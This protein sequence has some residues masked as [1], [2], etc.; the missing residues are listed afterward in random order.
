MRL[1]AVF[2]ALIFAHPLFPAASGNTIAID[3]TGN[4]WRT[5]ETN[6]LTTTATA[7]QKTAASSVCGMENLSPFQDPT[8]L[9]CKH[10]YLIK[11]D[12]AGNVLYATYL[13]GRSQDGGTAV[14]SDAEGNIYVTGYTY[15]RDFPISA[16]AAQAGNAGPL[17]PT[18]VTRTVTPFGP[19]Y[20]AA[21]GDVFVAKFDVNGDLLFSTL[22]GGSG[23][24]APTLI[25]VDSTGSVYVSGVTAS[26]DFPLTAGAVN[27]GAA[28]YFFARLNATGTALTYSTYFVASILAFDVDSMG[29]AY[30]TGDT[31]SPP[32]FGLGEP[33]LTTLDIQAGTVSQ[34]TD[35][36]AITTT[37]AG[38]AIAIT[39]SQEVFLA[40]S[41]APLAGSNSASVPPF[42][43]LGEAHL[44]KL[45]ADGG[46]VLAET[47]LSHSRFDAIVLDVAGNAYALGYGT[48][49]IPGTADQLLDS[50]CSPDGGAFVL[51]A[52]QEGTVVAATYFRH[53]DDTAVS[54]TSPGHI[55]LYR[56]R[57][58]TTVPL[59]LTSQPAIAFGCPENLAS[60][61]VAQGIAPGEIFALTGSG[62][63]PTQGIGALPDS[64][65]V[66]PTSL[67]GVQ[68]LFDSKPAP[69]L[70]VQANEIHAVA[71]FALSDQPVIE[72]RSDLS[73]ALLDLSRATYDPGIFNV[74][75]QGAIINQDGTVN[76]PGNPASLGSVV[77]IYATGLGT[78]IDSSRSLL[79][80]LADGE[81]TP[82]P[83]PYIMTELVAPQVT[84]AGIPGT[85]LWSGSAP[86]LVAG[87]TQVNVQLP[88]TLPPGTALGSVP[89]TLG[90]GPNVSPPV[91]MN[92]KQ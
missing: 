2:A 23:S 91:F 65:G 29:R 30:L 39:S 31:S 83:P 22:I 73:A 60:Q 79:N 63:G 26:S 59:D 19:S 43:P 40:V 92:L 67:G 17:T 35:L 76:A 72:V 24:D 12:G 74:N 18:V 37:G 87:V 47:K 34:S 64:S 56:T 41:P 75:G 7:F 52:N 86:G 53:G 21:G 8:P 70:F 50:P 68:V 69:L 45:P 57:S 16:G 85:T 42:R 49:A 62:L 13:G 28:P 4:V 81:V 77:S 9:Y 51:E 36:S 10:A 89:V 14:T 11:Q 88:S 78:L 82:I 80:P 25:G 1:A 55:L 61:T 84:F 46:H 48:G 90:V 3:S 38:T 33:Y 32:I 66:Y 6:P 44:V 5:G 20:I 15:S 71:P 58:S 54:L 27:R